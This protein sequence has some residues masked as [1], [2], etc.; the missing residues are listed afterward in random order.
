MKLKMNYT[1]VEAL[2]SRVVRDATDEVFKDS[3]NNCPRGD[4]LK[5]V[6]SVEKE[7]YAGDLEGRV[8]VGTDHWHPV[9]YGAPP[10][11]IRAFNSPVLTDGEN[12]FGKEVMHPGQRP[13]SFMRRSLYSKRRIHAG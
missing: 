4:T 3:V 7:H 11:I 8:Y 2:A 13:Q 5:L 12:F 1:H 10:H 6:D 9:E